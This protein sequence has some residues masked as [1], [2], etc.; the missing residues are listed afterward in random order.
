MKDIK[1]SLMIQISESI[2]TPEDMDKISNAIDLVLKDFNIEEKST[3]LLNISYNNNMIHLK[4]F[5]GIKKLEGRS[6]ATLK[7]YYFHLYKMLTDI[8]K[9]V[10]EITTNDLRY[11]LANWQ[12][13]RNITM[14][15]L[16]NMRAVYSSF[17]KYL[18]SDGVIETNPMDKIKKFKQ[19]KKLIEPF[20]EREL[21]TMFDNCDNV[22][23]RA[24]LEF[25]YS[26]GCR[27]SECVNV[28]INDIDFKN[29]T[30][31]IRCGKGNK[32]RITY[33]SDK[34][35]YWLEKYLEQ[36]TDKDIALWT[37]R[38]GPLTKAGIEAVVRRIGKKADV[39]AFPHKFRHTLATDMIRRGAPLPVVQQILGH[40]D[41]ATTM[42]YVEVSKQDA[43]T[44]HRKLI[45]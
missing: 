42:I 18:H 5:I 9:D 4:N 43:E 20:T 2:D 16:N 12:S 30:C 13:T 8:N 7:Q 17:F 39:H 28:T 37:G 31:L 3:E 33:I 19:Q 6:P 14:I 22:R 45:M 10:T 44:A 40:E 26:T 35:M 36:K 41:I 21:E 38:K 23:D 32:D 1:D 27:V 24:L 34:C 29:Q 15:S 25:L 11:Y